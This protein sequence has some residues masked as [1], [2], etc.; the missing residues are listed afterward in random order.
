MRALSLDLRER[1]VAAYDEGGVTQREVA[2]RFGVSEFTVRKLLRQ[3]R[4]T[5][6][7]APRYGNCGGA[8][9]ITGAHE[10]RLGQVLSARPDATL[11]ELRDALGLDCTEQAVHYALKRM[12]Y[13]YKK[14]AARQRTGP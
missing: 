10:A 3:R 14:N 11:S 9:K 2:G 5:G 8:R 12:G 1:I 6:D 7:I 13:S 4:E